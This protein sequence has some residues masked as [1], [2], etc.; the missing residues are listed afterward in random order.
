M[1]RPAD[2]LRASLAAED[3]DFV[4]AALDGTLSIARLGKHGR[5]FRYRKGPKVIEVFG[6]DIITLAD[7]TEVDTDLVDA[8]TEDRAVTPFDAQLFRNGGYG[9]RVGDVTLR[10]GGPEKKMGTAWVPCGLTGRTRLGDTVTWDHEWGGVYRMRLTPSGVE[11]HWTFAVRPPALRT[12][13]IVSGSIASTDGV[14]PLVDE[15]SLTIEGAKWADSSVGTDGFPS[16]RFGVIPFSAVGG[17]IPLIL[18]AGLAYPV[19]VDG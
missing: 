14:V 18:P 17:Y 7:G 2:E 16:P 11:T 15:E 19:R 4:T 12:R 9:M 6:P 5:G 1:P 3:A 10:F 8:V 13:L